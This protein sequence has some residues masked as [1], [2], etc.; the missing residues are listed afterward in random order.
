MIKI[1]IYI[2]L[3]VIV[4]LFIIKIKRTQH[5]ID[6][7][8]KKK[9]IHQIWFQGYENLPEKYKENIK[10]NKKYASNW[11]Y[12]F[13]DESKINKLISKNKKWYDNYKSYEHMHQKI[14]FAKYI[15]LY[16]Y[17]G[18]YI[19]MDASLIKNPDILFKKYP[20]HEI[21]LSYCQGTALE[22][23]MMAGVKQLI[24]NG[25]IV[26]ANPKN[27]IMNEF[28]NKLINLKWKSKFDIK[29]LEIN[30]STGPKIF[31]YIFN[32]LLKKYPNKVKVLSYDYFEPCMKEKCNITKNTITVHKH[33]VAWL[34]DNMKYFYKM[35]SQYRI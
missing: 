16:H 15:I 1:V 30:Y 14:D 17:G 10:N 21:F 29:Y 34:S 18:M 4:I 27:I 5:F 33:D 8:T 23:Y 22:H 20:I 31:T 2:L 32:K 12:I 6:F 11:K 28:I 3:I 7:K 19:D 26:V 13:W 35:Y 24:N 9:I 25:V